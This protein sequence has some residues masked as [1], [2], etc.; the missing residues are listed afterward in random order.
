MQ[1]RMWHLGRPGAADVGSTPADMDG[2]RFGIGRLFTFQGDHGGFEFAGPQ[3]SFAIMRVRE[4][5][6]E[7]VLRGRWRVH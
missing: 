7:A 5:D 3:N 1:W 2:Y 6:V 4:F